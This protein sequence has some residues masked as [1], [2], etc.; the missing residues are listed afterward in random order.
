[1]V[2]VVYLESWWFIPN[3]IPCPW[4]LSCTWRT[5][6]LPLTR[7]LVC[8]VCRIQD[9]TR[10]ASGLPITGS[11][12]CTWRAGGLSLTGVPCP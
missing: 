11:L 5:G 4:C 9:F 12:S 6:G 7:F 8:G 1:M 3:G 10:R 2:S